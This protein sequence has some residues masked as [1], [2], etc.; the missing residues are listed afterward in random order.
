MNAAGRLGLFSAGAVV[1]FAAA[2]GVAAV[3]VPGDPSGGPAG[4]PSEG[5]TMKDESNTNMGTATA[6][7]APAGVSLSSG[8]YV[9]SPVTAPA[10]TGQA[11]EL[12]FQIMTAQGEPLTEYAV[13]HEKDLHLIVVRSDGTGFRHVHPALEA[14][15][16]TW[17]L[18]WEWD[19]A[20]TY[21]LY[22]DFTPGD[23][24][25]EGVTLTRTV[26][27][28]GEYRP[29]AAEVTQTDE[30]DGYTVTIDGDLVAAS[31][32]DLTISVSRDGEPVTAL[33]P[34]LG[35]FG[36]L[37]ALRDGDL[38]Y[39]HVHA[40]G[41]EPQPGDTSGPEI[42]FMA[43]APTAGRYLLYLDFQVGGQVHTAE[44]V[45]DAT[46]HGSND[47]KTHEA[48]HEE[49]PHEEAPHGH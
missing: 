12:R 35:A 22:A 25:G 20:G 41:D 7:G 49:A 15:S 46:G 18:P 9:L 47:A 37:V 13:A 11:G 8:G 30:V 26:Q 4:G 42:A 45:L 19:A 24:D 5:E 10:V 38:A 40:D 39:L 21:R 43:E 27:V 6:S 3:A 31:M 1:A 23:R 33:E 14:D 32:S 28:A 2:F 36:H 17:S 44:F 34:Y 29:V 48:P 16:G